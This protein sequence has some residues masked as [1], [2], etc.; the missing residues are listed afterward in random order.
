[1]LLSIEILHD[2]EHLMLWYSVMVFG[3]TKVMQDIQYQ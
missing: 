1:M 2:S 3:Q